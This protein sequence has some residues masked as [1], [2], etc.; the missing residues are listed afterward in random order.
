MVAGPARDWALSHPLGSLLPPPRSPAPDSRAPNYQLRYLLTCLPSLP[1]DPMGCR[2]R[3][4]TGAPGPRHG[5]QRACVT[6]VHPRVPSAP[7]ASRGG[8]LRQEAEWTWHQVPAP[9]APP[10]RR[11]H[12]RGRLVYA[13]CRVCK[14]CPSGACVGLVLP[15]RPCPRSPSGRTVQGPGCWVVFPA[16]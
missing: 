4:V 3:E 13:T 7:R 9:K 14:A 16:P 1:L 6:G 2:S 8:V 10:K 12:S 11:S 15:L 5:L